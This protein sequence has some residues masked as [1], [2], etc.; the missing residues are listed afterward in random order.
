MSKKLL[1]IVALS[2]AIL[3][4]SA[5]AAE[6]K[7]GWGVEVGAGKTVYGSP[8]RDKNFYFGE[9][10]KT[11][12]DI[13][14]T[15]P[16]FSHVKEFEHDGSYSLFAGVNYAF[17]NGFVV[18][19]EL[20]YT[21]NDQKSKNHSHNENNHHHDTAKHCD[22]NKND[23]S[24]AHLLIESATLLA[25][26]KYLIDFDSSIYPFIGAGVGISRM[27]LSF[28][29]GENRFSDLDKM[30]FAYMGTAGF[31]LHASKDLELSLA[32]TIRGT[33][34]IDCDH[35]HHHNNHHDYNSSNDEHHNKNRDLTSFDHLKN[36]DQNIEA[37]VM[38]KL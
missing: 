31:M 17:C 24:K 5:N 16:V 32:Y 33:T 1:K 28:H 25:K 9:I 29:D 34:D 3:G 22:H 26:G 4:F 18:G 27:E 11:Y 37:S 7:E 35:E 21:S 10:T 38:F 36:N 6:Y 30:G 20:S 19:A 15:F 8:N 14:T 12:N 13:T 23:H 2:A